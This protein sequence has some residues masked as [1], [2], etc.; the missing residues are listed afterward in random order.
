MNDGRRSPRVVL[1]VPIRIVGGESACE[2]QT[3]VV[4]RH[5]A[6][7]LC[8]VVYPD[9][10]NLRI[11]NLESGETAP[12]RVVWWGQDDLQGMHKAGAE[13]L[14]ERPNFWGPAYRSAA[15]SA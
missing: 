6:L 2:G 14:E 9:E 5:G 12:F 8:P 7:V 15:A 4:N 10:S 11:T 3:A 13:M 1:Q